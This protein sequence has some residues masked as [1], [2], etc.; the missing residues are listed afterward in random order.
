LVFFYQF[1]F[2]NNLTRVENSTIT[3]DLLITT[4]A[5]HIARENV[6]SHAIG[7]SLEILF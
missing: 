3:G 2:W 5:S 1:N 7:A 6:S 4:G